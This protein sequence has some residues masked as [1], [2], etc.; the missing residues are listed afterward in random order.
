MWMVNVIC[1]WMTLQKPNELKRRKFLI[2]A[3]R[4]SLKVKAPDK[5]ERFDKLRYSVID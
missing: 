5:M 1:E 3:R 4:E 2:V